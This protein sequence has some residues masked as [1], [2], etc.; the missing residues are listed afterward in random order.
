M[1]CS[2]ESQN[3]EIANSKHALVRSELGPG[4]GMI[5]GDEKSEPSVK[6]VELD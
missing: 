6:K 1:M 4:Q 5:A 3:T 2:V